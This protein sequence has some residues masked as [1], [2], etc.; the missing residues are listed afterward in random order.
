MF[1]VKGTVLNTF[2]VPGSEK[3]PETKYNVQILGKEATKDG[4][5]RNGLVSFSVPFDCFKKLADLVG[6][7]VSF[8]VGI[9]VS[10]GRLQ[11]FFPKSV[12]PDEITILASA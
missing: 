7:E 6:A 3:Y 2:T 11:T 5:I 10:S 4:Q 1:T 12:K 8:P 9:F